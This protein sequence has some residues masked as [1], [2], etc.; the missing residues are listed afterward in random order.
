MPP[1]PDLMCSVPQDHAAEHNIDH[2]LAGEPFAF[3]AGMFA[4]SEHGSDCS[5]SNR[6]T[7][8]ASEGQSIGPGEL[9]AQNMPEPANP[10]PV[11][12]SY[13]LSDL[14]D[15]CFGSAHNSP[16]PSPA[17]AEPSSQPLDAHSFHDINMIESRLDDAHNE[18]TML[19]IS[20]R[21]NEMR[22]D[23]HVGEMKSRLADLD[24]NM[25][26]VNTRGTITSLRLNEVRANMDELQSRIQA[27]GSA[28]ELEKQDVSADV[29]SCG[30]VLEE[31]RTIRN[32]AAEQIAEGLQALQVAR[33]E[34]KAHAD[35]A[36]A[37]AASASASSQAAS[38][39]AA[40]SLKRKREEESDREAA[41]GEGDSA[42][43]A[44]MPSALKRRKTG[45]VVHKVAQTAAYA[46]IGAVAAW[47][48]LA[49]A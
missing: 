43:Q 48:A 36:Q 8:A 45:R 35:A 6:A 7:R 28:L 33:E 20:R 40:T 12:F 10:T 42:V 14:P 41:I 5:A 26:A 22:F 2:M 13:T 21:S 37:A 38:Q 30:V 31:M 25:L 4:P 19:R 15:N 24:Q 44:A 34:V 16:S 1:L 11:K 27:L 47:T 29:H 3:S 46:T 18:I 39:T 49:F 32:D 9:S 23:D 17:A